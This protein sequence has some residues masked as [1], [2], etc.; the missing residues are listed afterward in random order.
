[1]TEL[2]KK[3]PE[4][5]NINA[6]SD[7][8]TY[9]LPAAGWVSILHRISGFLM[10]LLLPFVLWMFDTSVSSEISFEKFKAAFNV[11]L[12]WAPGWFFKLI[13]LALIWA[14]L[15]HLTAGLRHLWMD[16][17]HEAVSKE[18]GRSSAVAT[19]VISIALTVVLGAKLF[20][21]Y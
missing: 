13:A 4:F 14:Y 18:F 16:T 7:L 12:G 5:R 20:G 3:R 19:L 10:F 8:P 11:G 1:M 9:R 2:T 17:H 21:L 6:L 15:H